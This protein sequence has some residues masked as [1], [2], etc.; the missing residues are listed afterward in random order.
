MIRQKAVTFLYS[1]VFKLSIGNKQYIID[2]SFTTADQNVISRLRA[3]KFRE[4]VEEDVIEKE[5]VDESVDLPKEKKK[6]SKSK[7]GDE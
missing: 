2:K 4:E 7:D 6:K 3:L 5:T 1:G